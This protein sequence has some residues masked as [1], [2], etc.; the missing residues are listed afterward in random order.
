MVQAILHARRGDMDR[1]RAWYDRAT[2]A[3]TQAKDDL[4]SRY[5]GI[6]Y[7]RAEAEALINRKPPRR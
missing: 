4:D 1:A 6:E 2:H 5:F 7:A 3:A